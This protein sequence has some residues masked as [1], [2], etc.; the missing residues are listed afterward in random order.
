MTAMATR[1]TT[2]AQ[3]GQPLLLLASPMGTFPE[4][5]GMDFTSSYSEP[6]KI[7]KDVLNSRPWEEDNGTSG[8]DESSIKIGLSSTMPH[9]SPCSK[10]GSVTDLNCVSEGQG[11]LGM[12][13]PTSVCWR[14]SGEFSPTTD[15]K[16]PYHVNALH[17]CPEQLDQN[18]QP[19]RYL[20]RPLDAP[21]LQM[22]SQNHK[23][24]TDLNKSRCSVDLCLL[25]NEYCYNGAPS[26]SIDG[27]LECFWKSRPHGLNCFSRN[28]LG[29]LFSS[30]FLVSE[31]SDSVAIPSIDEGSN[32]D[33]KEDDNTEDDNNVENDEDDDDDVF[34]ELPSYRE[35]LLSRCLS[36]SRYKWSKIARRLDVAHISCDPTS[37][38]WSDEEA[39]NSEVIAQVTS[40]P[41]VFVKWRL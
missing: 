18:P 16:V 13:C 31:S 41:A 17:G 15:L 25:P 36:R 29:D 34:P 30:G 24:G 5:N 20:N 9:A 12:R 27:Q 28:Q 33:D 26:A 21:V 37:H 32:T 39:V 10:L 14:N 38:G 35:F 40:T 7:E 22:G 23:L 3:E 2:N 1:T 8:V 19:P 11:S 4:S 6:R